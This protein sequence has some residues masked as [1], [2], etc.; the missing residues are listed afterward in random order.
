MTE[1]HAGNVQKSINDC[2]DSFGRASAANDWG[3]AEKA[4]LK[5]MQ[6]A[7]I[8]MRESVA[9]RIE[10]DSLAAELLAYRP[11]RSDRP[12]APLID[13]YNYVFTGKQPWVCAAKELRKTVYIN[14][15]AG[16]TQE[17]FIPERKTLCG[18]ATS[19]PV[20]ERFESGGW[21]RRHELCPD[22]T[23]LL[24]KAGL[25]GI[26]AVTEREGGE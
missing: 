20:S 4:L 3:A 25:L 15:G 21:P 11:T 8:V 13:G 1:F 7:S 6:Q 18:R 26:D 5:L 22:C 23:A 16:Y 2:F 17:Y 19:Y 24:G 10:A 14:A 9:I 12:A